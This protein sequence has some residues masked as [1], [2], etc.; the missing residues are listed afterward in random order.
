MLKFSV[1]ELTCP[2]EWSLKTFTGLK[3][4][5]PRFDCRRQEAAPEG[6]PVVS[7]RRHG[8]DAGRRLRSTALVDFG[9]RP[10]LHYGCL[11]G[12]H[13]AETGARRVHCPGVRYGH[14]QSQ[15]PPRSPGRN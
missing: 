8:A 9:V 4:P 5:T 11:P 2:E 12:H 7:P 13:P 6:L 1:N 14:D 10:T 3:T 15:L